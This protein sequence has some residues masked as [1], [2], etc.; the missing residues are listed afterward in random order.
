MQL[1]AITSLPNFIKGIVE[2]LEN[3]DFEV[4]NLWAFL[5]SSTLFFL[6]CFQF[7]IATKKFI[8]SPLDVFSL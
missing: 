3:E 8:F 7:K 1:I 5:D 6:Y 2:S 4:W